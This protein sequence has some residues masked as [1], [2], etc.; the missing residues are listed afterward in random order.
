MEI[1]DYNP[2]YPEENKHRK[3]KINAD[4]SISTSASAQSTKDGSR[5]SFGRLRVAQISTQLDLKQIHDDLPLFYDTELG[6]TGSNTYTEATA[7]TL[8]ETSANADFVIKQTYQR[9]N[10]QSG[11]GHQILMTFAGFQ[12]ETNV[13]KR[14]GY[15]S[16]NT[17]T[18]FNSDLDGIFLEMDTDGVAYF[19]TYRRGTLTNSVAQTNWNTDKF[20]GSGPSGKTID[21]SKTN[22]MELTFEWLGVGS[23]TLRFVIDGI[24]YQA[25]A[26]MNAQ[27]TT[28]VYMASGNQPLRYEIRQS[29]AGSGSFKQICSTV[30]SEGSINEIGVIQSENL[31]ASHVNAN[32]TAN[33]YALLGIRLQED[34]TDTAIDILGFN[35]LALT[36][37]NF[38]YKV[39]LNPTV[40]GTFNYADVTNST[41]MIAKGDTVGNPSTNTVT[42]GTLLASGYINS[43]GGGGEGQLDV[44]LVNA[45]RLGAK[46]DGT[47]DE[48]I[49]AVQPLT[50]NL[51]I[52]GSLNWRERS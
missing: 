41:L 33:T 44:E 8:L 11:K 27:N 50:A 6:G 45:L 18:P 52:L 19:K 12:A 38:L 23:T 2:N 16:S 36:S 43:S 40:N 48:I 13:Q 49:L 14:I 25:H 32:D 34:K 29:G 35:A 15:F 47:Q 10:Y 7:S 31:G 9:S 51:D 24:Y 5:D 26:F 3:L 42:G 39:I 4:G 30:G 28:D 21:W 46:I 37:D 22:I 20:D 17:T 1:H